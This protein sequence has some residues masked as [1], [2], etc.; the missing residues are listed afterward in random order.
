MNR[1]LGEEKRQGR[2]FL[3]VFFPRTCVWVLVHACGYQ[4]I[5]DVGSTGVHGLCSTG[6]RSTV[7]LL[8][9]YTKNLGKTSKIDR[10]PSRNSSSW[11]DFRPI[12]LKMFS[13]GIFVFSMASSL[14]PLVKLWY[15][16]GIEMWYFLSASSI[17]MWYFI[18][19]TMTSPIFLKL[20]ISRIGI[21][22]CTG[23][24]VAVI[25]VISLWLNISHGDVFWKKI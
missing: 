22:G 20:I 18:R 12:F 5:C 13:Y 8:V 19:R 3:I 9:T 14:F 16:P 21:V 4:Y 24:S 1:Q 11:Y 6:V 2:R 17:S 7:I 15:F 23:Y 10:L 25:S